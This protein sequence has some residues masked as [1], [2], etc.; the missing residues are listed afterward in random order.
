MAM[1][2][3]F[4]LVLAGLVLLALG[5]VFLVV[6]LDKA[7]KIA[8][9]VGAACGVLGLVLGAV[10]SPSAARTIGASRTGNIRNRTGSAVTGIQGTAKS[11]ACRV[12]AD[13]TG[14]IEGGDGD[15]TTGVRLG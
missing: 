5:V 8:S 14:D 7:D 6:G 9:I 2:K 1:L 12:I 3:H 10:G 4:W 15:A 11:P 13:R